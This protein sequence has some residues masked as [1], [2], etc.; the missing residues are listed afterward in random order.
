[1]LEM[2]ELYVEICDCESRHRGLNNLLPRLPKEPQPLL[3]RPRI[4]SAAAQQ[5]ERVVVVKE[6]VFRWCY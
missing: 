1:M 3:A 6:R 4:V 5:R 2:G